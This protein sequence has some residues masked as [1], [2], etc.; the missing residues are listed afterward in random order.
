MSARPLLSICI[1]TYNRAD[2]LAPMLK[3]LCLEASADD[4]QVEVVVSDN[5]S[6]DNTS[7]VVAAAS[8]LHPVSYF[9][10]STNV[11]Q[12]NLILAAER[13]QG[14]FCWVLGDDDMILKGKLQR[15]VT[16]LRENPDVDYFYVNYLTA[17]IE[18][19]NELLRA[20]AGFTP[21]ITQ[22][23]CQE[24]GDRRLAT[25]ELIFDIPN[26]SPAEMNTSI[27]CSVFRRERWTRY[28]SLLTFGGAPRVSAADRT[29]DDTFP[30]VKLLAH[31]M[32]GRPAFYVA[33][34]C[35]LMG[36]GG[37][38]WLSDWPV[39]SIVGVTEALDLYDSLGFDRERLTRLWRA[40]FTKVV[41]YMPLIGPLRG[42]P[43]MRGFSW[44]AYLWRVRHRV[45]LL[46]PP[47]LRRLHPGSRLDRSLP[48]PVFVA[49]RA[50]W[51][52]ARLVRVRATRAVRERVNQ[53][54][55]PLR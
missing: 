45:R 14:E 30:H 39:I 42:A 32:M 36:Q 37:Q 54:G 7:E 26:V 21:E 1:P 27:V 25:W 50:V 16:A 23:V 34:P 51:R 3:A 49:M 17:P 5:C 29:L 12:R 24:P 20:N 44:P 46:L 55:M 48:R 6:T 40:H 33:E 41:R 22:C 52:A 15:V 18:R 2:L 11:G 19:R 53:G 31:A 35:A 4:D 43:S 28:S 38:E 13:A 47:L 8:T 10:N 9:V